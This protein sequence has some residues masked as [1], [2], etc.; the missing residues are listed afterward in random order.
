MG[1]IQ[2]RT[3]ARQLWHSNSPGKVH[4]VTFPAAR[5]FGAIPV[6]APL[7]GQGE[8]R[9][10]GAGTERKGPLVVGWL[11]PLD[12]DSRSRSGGLPRVAQRTSRIGI[13][14]ESGGNVRAGVR[15]M[16]FRNCGRGPSLPRCSVTLKVTSGF[17]S[18]PM[19]GVRFCSNLEGMLDLASRPSQ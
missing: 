18:R 9:R 14:I 11:R 6:W 7:A 8:V 1:A 13:L 5:C 15:E 19:A 2:T 3:V 4:S 12:P 10:K 17:L 16:P